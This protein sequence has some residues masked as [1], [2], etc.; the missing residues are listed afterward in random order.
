MNVYDVLQSTS[1]TTKELIKRCIRDIHGADRESARDWYELITSSF[2]MVEVEPTTYTMLG[3]ICPDKVCRVFAIDVIHIDA[4]SHQNTASTITITP[5]L[6]TISFPKLLGM[7]VLPENVLEVGFD[8]FAEGFLR[9]MMP[10]ADPIS[11]WKLRKNHSFD[12]GKLETSMQ[13]VLAQYND[14]KGQPCG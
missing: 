6:Q 5:E 9:A 2:P 10:G 7:E 3:V 8:E 4:S 12:E 13:Y 14:S 1:V 11:Y